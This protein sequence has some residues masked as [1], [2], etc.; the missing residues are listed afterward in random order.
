[1]HHGRGLS[2]QTACRLA[3]P[4]WLSCGHSVTSTSRILFA[5]ASIESQT[6]STVHGTVL[7]HQIK[8]AGM[9]LGCLHCV[10]ILSATAASQAMGD[11][12]SRFRWSMQSTC[13]TCD[14]PLSAHSGASSCSWRTCNAAANH[15]TEH[16][17][18]FPRESE[19]TWPA[20]RIAASCQPPATLR[21]SVCSVRSVVCH[22]A[23]LMYFAAS[24]SPSC[25]W[26]A[27]QADRRV[28]MLEPT[29]ISAMPRSTTF[30]HQASWQFCC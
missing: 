26:P 12:T 4:P 1:M 30:C 16:R 19:L 9:N 24:A 11:S 18:A 13:I 21:S 25:D 2:C 8:A 7:T 22:P 29:H 27:V 5:K 17:Q 10:H 14:R 23:P 20:R 3:K 28:T 15:G 6:S